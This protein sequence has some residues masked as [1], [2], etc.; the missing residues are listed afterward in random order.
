L[1]PGRSRR[2][3]WEEVAETVNTECGSSFTGKQCQSKF[4]NLVNEYNV[5]K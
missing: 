3:F 5:I 1:I 4:N 2:N